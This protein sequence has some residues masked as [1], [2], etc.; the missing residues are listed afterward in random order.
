MA[1]AALSTASQSESSGTA[2]ARQEPS[3]TAPDTDSSSAASDDE[4]PST[5]TRVIPK[6]T[7][8]DSKELK[9]LGKKARKVSRIL[10]KQRQ[11]VQEARAQLQKDS[12]YNTSIELF[13]PLTSLRTGWRMMTSFQMLPKGVSAYFFIFLKEPPEGSPRERLLTRLLS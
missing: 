8:L 13:P 9:L 1:E 11:L 3:S 5:S 12:K 7:G 4:T 2:A 10:N 6:T